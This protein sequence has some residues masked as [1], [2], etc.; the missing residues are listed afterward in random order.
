MIFKEKVLKIYNLIYEKKMKIS[1]QVVK[2]KLGAPKILTID[3]TIDNILKN[4][5]SVS[6]YGDGE[7][8]II[9]GQG[10]RFQEYNSNLSSRL[11]EI[12]QNDKKGLLVCISD[13]YNDPKWMKSWAYEYTWKL[14][15]QNRRKWY[16][17]LNMSTVYG[18][19]FITRCY[20]DWKDNA[21]SEKWFTKLKLIWQDEDIIFIEG[22]Y[23]R[24]GLSNDLF[25]NAKSIHRI[26]CPEKNAY[27][28]YKEILKVAMQQ[29]KEKLFLIA[30]GPTATVL[31]YDLCER[32]YR[33]MDIGHVDIE[34]EWFLRKATDKIA[35]YN[36]YTSEAQGGDEV[37]EYAGEEFEK[38]IICRIEKSN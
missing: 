9:S 25:S 24:L 29:S 27:N 2:C 35:I 4:K 31:S 19:A 18:N 28:M 34:Y 3:E 22:K 20:M 33:A 6:R 10:I 1:D 13:I 8:K 5:V 23:S 32:G 38:Q 14:V 37:L 36:K 12:L 30:L 26:L 15:A 16:E 21:N 7:M 17:F 11:R